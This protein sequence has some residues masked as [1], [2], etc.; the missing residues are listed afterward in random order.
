MTRIQP[1]ALATHD[2]AAVPLPDALRVALLDAP[3]GVLHELG[4]AH[5]GDAEHGDRRRQSGRRQ[6]KAETR[7]EVAG[8]DGAWT[9]HQHR[10]GAHGEQ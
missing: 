5:A 8:R 2:G 10:G 3:V 9:D 7:G 6:V 1:R 4:G